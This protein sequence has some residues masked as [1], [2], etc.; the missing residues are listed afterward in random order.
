MDDD[1]KKTLDRI[2]KIVE[3][4]NRIVRK[5]HRHL[6]IQRFL[7]VSG[8]LMVL[9]VAGLM[10]YFVQPYL[11]TLDTA[12]QVIEKFRVEQLGR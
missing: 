1:D 4:N 11:G 5:L 7:R 12:V 9:V 8:L 6:M 3:H 2:L 10:Y